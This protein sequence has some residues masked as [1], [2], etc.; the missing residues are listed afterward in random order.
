VSE[1]DQPSDRDAPRFPGFREGLEP[2]LVASEGG[3]F[4]KLSISIPAALMRTVREVVDETGASVSGVIAASLR[5]Y[6]DEVEQARLDAA[7]EADREENLRW[8]YAAA[9]MNA[10]LLAGVEW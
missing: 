4:E 3:P 1:Y 7:L 2:Y 10:R 5:R 6:V 9:P 8:A